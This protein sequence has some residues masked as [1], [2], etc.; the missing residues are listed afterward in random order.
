MPGL[1]RPLRH[2]RH[3]P[4]EFARTS[5]IVGYKANRMAPAAWHAKI[6]PYAQRP[7]S[8]METPNVETPHRWPLTDR[9]R[10]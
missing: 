7:L 1:Y 8:V 4:Q 5:K 10:S 6:A 3:K 9:Q 2:T